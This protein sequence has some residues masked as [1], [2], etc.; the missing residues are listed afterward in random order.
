MSKRTAR[1]RRREA[2]AKRVAIAVRVI[3]RSQDGT[4]IAWVVPAM[5]GA[6]GMEYHRVNRKGNHFQCYKITP[7]NP[8]GITCLGNRIRKAGA[9]RH[10]MG[11]A[12]HEMERQSRTI[13]FWHDEKAVEH[14]HRAGFHLAGEAGSLYVT[15]R[16]AGQ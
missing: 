9:C 6:S 14:H 10:V 15:H 13:R 1:L 7:M 12:A 3:E 5:T 2:W 11:V 4:P 8:S 16:K